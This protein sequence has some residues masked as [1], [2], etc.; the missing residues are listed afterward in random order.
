MKIGIMGAMTEEVSQLLQ[1]MSCTQS[2][3]RGMREYISGEL[4][5]KKVTVVFSRWGKV[6]ASSTATTLI[7]R[8]GVNCLV[9]TGVAGALDTSLNIGDIVVADTLLQHDMNASALPGIERHEIPLL[10]ISRFTAEPRHADAALRAAETYLTE[11]LQAD[12][13]ADTL[14]E[15]QITKPR[16]VTGTIA[17]GDQFIADDSI[18]LALREQIPDLKCVEMEGAAV[19]QVAYEYKIPCIVLRTI[20]D[21]ADNSAVVNFPRFVNRVASHFTCG[22]VLRLLDVIQK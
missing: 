16:V 11:D 8:Y 19:A 10:G 12:V 9:F 18:A 2:E 15:F 4:R 3:T 20:S 13:D 7:E 6:A 17:S 1:H 5:G 21:K 14:H 22:S